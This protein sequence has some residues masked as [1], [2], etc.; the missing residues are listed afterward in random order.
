MSAYDDYMDAAQRIKD[1]STAV[2][3]EYKR[4]S[5]AAATL[6]DVNQTLVYNPDMTVVRNRGGEV[7]GY[8]YKYTTPTQPNPTSIDINSNNDSGSYGAERNRSSTYAGGVVTDPQSTDKMRG[9]GL[10]AGLVSGAWAATSVISRLGKK[11]A[12]GA[13][14][15]LD[16]CGVRFGLQFGPLTVD[17]DAAT[18][19]RALFKVDDENKT[20][21]YRD[22]DTFGA[23]RT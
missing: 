19:V 13:A 17:A 11:L 23:I 1:S 7:I 5:D 14:D 20:W 12:N 6:C 21:M 8:N 18:A 16:A 22:E 9:T 4:V 10:V 3:A 2:D 15:A